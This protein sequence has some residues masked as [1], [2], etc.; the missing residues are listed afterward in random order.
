M[1]WTFAL[2][3]MESLR[4]KLAWSDDTGCALWWE[5]RQGIRL[6]PEIQ[7]GKPCISGTR[8]PSSAIW[9]LPAAGETAE[10]VASEYEVEV[11]DVERAFEWERDVRAV[12]D[13]KTRV[14][15]R[16]ESQPAGLSGARAG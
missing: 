8:V 9:S 3:G 14:P 5:P 15:R 1:G 13:T 11:T 12:L 4:E 2:R 16:R 6:D 10:S 7:F